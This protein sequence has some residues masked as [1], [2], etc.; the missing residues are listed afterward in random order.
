MNSPS[1]RL[2]LLERGFTDAGIGRASDTRSK[3][4]VVVLLAEWP[5]FTGR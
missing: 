4:C 2:T 1:H 3:V 5:R